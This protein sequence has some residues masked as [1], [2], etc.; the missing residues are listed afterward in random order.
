MRLRVE[1]ALPSAKLLSGVAQQ[2]LFELSLSEGK[3]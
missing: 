1:L 3:L 2:E